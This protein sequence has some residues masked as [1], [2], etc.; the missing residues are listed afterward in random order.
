M[1][2]TLAKNA[3][4]GHPLS[5]SCP[6]KNKRVGHPARRIDGKVMI[7]QS[8]GSRS[9]QIDLSGNRHFTSVEEKDR[10]VVARISAV[11][12]SPRLFDWQRD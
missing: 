3:R 7:D 9:N 5:W 2:P 11:R 10:R 8:D 12:S 1:L 4:M 6:Q